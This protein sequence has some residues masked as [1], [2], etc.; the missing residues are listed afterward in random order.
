MSGGINYDATVTLHEVENAVNLACSC[1]GHGPND[2]E[3][4]PA[5]VVWHELVAMTQNT[6]A[7]A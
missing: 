4:C 3:V 7:G 2:P 1:G 6:N 5:C